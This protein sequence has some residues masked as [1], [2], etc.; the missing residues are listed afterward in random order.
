MLKAEY[1]G[2]AIELGQRPEGFPFPG[3][4]AEAYAKIKTTEIQDPDEPGYGRST[5]IDVLVERLRTQGMK[6][7]PV[8]NEQAVLVYALPLDSNDVAA[9]CLFPR[10]L[11]TRDGMDPGLAKLIAANKVGVT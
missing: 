3:I 7:V 8:M 11:E 6:I 10:H 5:P 9:D 1:V 4:S 2:L